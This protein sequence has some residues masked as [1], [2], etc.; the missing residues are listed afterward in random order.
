LFCSK[1]GKGNTEGALFCAGCGAGLTGEEPAKK[2]TNWSTTAGTI[3]I[4]DGLIMVVLEPVYI[5]AALS[6]HDSGSALSWWVVPT[7]LAV[8]GTM[9]IVGG[10][11]ALRRKGWGWALAGAIAAI[12]PFLVF[13]VASVILTI[14][15]KDE[16]Q[17]KPT[18]Q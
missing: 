15:A 3:E 16:F 7:V 11:C 9:A 18:Q 17:R 1:C 2:R 14:M 6:P 12:L 4:I 5:H 8:F 10:V 13:G